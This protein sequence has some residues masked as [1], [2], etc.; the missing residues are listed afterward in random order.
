MRNFFVSSHEAI[1]HG[2]RSKQHYSRCCGKNEYATLLLS[3]PADAARAVKS[4]TVGKVVIGMGAMGVIRQK[5]P[6][7]LN[8]RPYGNGLL[9]LM[10]LDM[11]KIKKNAHI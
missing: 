9:L 6:P 1:K 7:C 3:P 8:K 10:F 2:L 4:V 11:I 5:G